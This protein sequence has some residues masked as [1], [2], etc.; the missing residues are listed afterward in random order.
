MLDYNSIQP[1]EYLNLITLVLLEDLLL[2]QMQP[3]VNAFGSM[4]DLQK[5]SSSL[6][7]KST[8][9]WLGLCR[10]NNL[11]NILVHLRIYLFFLILI[12]FCRKRTLSYARTQTVVTL[13]TNTTVINI[14]WWIA[15]V[16]YNIVPKLSNATNMI[17][18]F[19]NRARDKFLNFFFMGQFS[20][21]NYGSDLT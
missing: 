2:R 5:S 16:V 21:F 7:V 11:L 1:F 10:W 14:N 19:Q 17:S 9:L 13:L 15:N 8:F 6:C 20:N 4:N 12:L 3:P 18:Y